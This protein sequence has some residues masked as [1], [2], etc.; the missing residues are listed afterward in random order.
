MKIYKIVDF[1]ENIQTVDTS[2]TRT[3]AFKVTRKK[4]LNFLTEPFIASKA[5][6]YALTSRRGNQA[7]GINTITDCTESRSTAQLVLSAAATN[8]DLGP[9]RFSNLNPANTP[10]WLNSLD[11]GSHDKKNGLYN[12]HLKRSL[13]VLIC[14]LLL[15]VVTPIILAAWCLVKRDG[16]P[17]FFTQDRI[18]RDGVSFQCF[19]LRTMHVDAEQRLKHLCATDD[20]VAYEWHTFQ[21]LTNDP[22]ISKLGRFLRE[23]SIDELPQIFNVLLGDM[24]IVGPRPF[25]SSQNQL[26]RDA[27]GS[28]YYSLRPGVTGLWQV[29]GRGASKFVDRV[30]YDNEYASK[31]SFVTDILLILKTVKVVFCKTGC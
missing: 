3:G 14:L 31:L 9:T 17:G 5:L 16:G 24:S 30:R 7:K 13:D 23:T 15:P 26:Y 11:D 25:M 2:R 4:L 28:H 29:E 22:R 8:A 1:S 19:K 12:K 21:K 27:G 10:H 6:R 20:K 18:G